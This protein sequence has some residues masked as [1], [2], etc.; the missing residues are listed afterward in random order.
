MDATPRTWTGW[1]LTLASHVLAI[2][3]AVCLCD[4][5]LGVLR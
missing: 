3:G 1:L 4:A 5:I 2:Y